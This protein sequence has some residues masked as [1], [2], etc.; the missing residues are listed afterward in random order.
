MCDRNP[1]LAKG[2]GSGKSPLG[3][4]ANESVIRRNQQPEKQAAI[5]AGKLAD[6]WDRQSAGKC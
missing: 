2:I 5:P 4:L 1:H 6:D 3:C